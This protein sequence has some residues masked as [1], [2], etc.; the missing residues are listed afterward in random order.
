M[1]NTKI[2]YCIYATNQLIIFDCIE[3]YLGNAAQCHLEPLFKLQK[4]H[5]LELYTFSDYN[6]HTAANILNKLE[7]GC[8]LYTNWFTIGL[9][10]WCTEYANDGMLPP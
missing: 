7:Y 10:Y 8:K 5:I 3:S 4:F 6:A 2:L 1:L 9:E